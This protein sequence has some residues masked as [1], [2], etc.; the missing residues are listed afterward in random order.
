MRRVVVTGMGAITPIGLTAPAFWENTC[1]GR[2]G[3]SVIEGFDSKDLPVRIAGEIK[4]FDAAKYLD[5]RN[6]RRMDRFSQFGTVAAIEACEN[7]GLDLDG[8]DL[9]RIGVVVGTGIGGLR[10]IEA[11]HIRLMGKGFDKVSPFMIPKLMANA[12]SG[13]ISIIYGL[14]GPNSAMVTACASAA[15]AIGTAAAII[16]L[17]A[18]DAMFTGG[19]EA[20]ITPLGIAGFDAMNAISRRNDEPEKARRPFDKMRDGFV[21]GEGAGIVVIEELEHARKRGAEIYG[22]LIGYGMSG[23]AYHIAAPEPDGTGA[24][25]AMRTALESAKIAP[26]Q[27]GYINAHG[28]GTPL[29]DISECEAIRLVLGENAKKVAVSS[30]KSMIGHLLGA[31]GGPE[32]IAAV[33]AVR[34]GVIPPTINLENP[35]PKCDLDFVP[36]E[37]R[38]TQVEVAMSNSFGFGG[39][40]ACLVVRKFED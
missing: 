18:A 3:I 19:A 30:T 5:R 32:F 13:N 17:G 1:R 26:E 20:A 40:N 24:A 29:G 15:N 14:R 21:M 2:N 10:E 28:T 7:S 37:A 22:E 23:D 16:R 31:S 39:H 6:A 9:K 12:V 36:I 11:Q 38:E 8:E 34:E 25:I 33:M 27:L 35:D 4:D